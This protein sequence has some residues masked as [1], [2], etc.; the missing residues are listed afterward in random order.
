MIEEI[1]KIV[2]NEL[3]AQG[4]VDDL[5]QDMASR[6]A[7]ALSNEG[8]KS[9]LEYLNQCGMTN[10]AVLDHLKEATDG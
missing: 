7:S 5:V 3:G 2:D 1:Q 10:E 6:K 8:L 9:Q 4:V